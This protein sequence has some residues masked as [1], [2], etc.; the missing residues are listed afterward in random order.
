MAT[1]DDKNDENDDDE[2]AKSRRFSLLWR[3][4]RKIGSA[5]AMPA[6]QVGRRE[7]FVHH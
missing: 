6:I 3:R 7:L 1:H 2:W 5:A 4:W